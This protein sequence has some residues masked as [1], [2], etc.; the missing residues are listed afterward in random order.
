MANVNS[1]DVV[2]PSFRLDEEILLNICN[3]EIPEGVLATFYIVADNPAMEIPEGLLKLAL[4]DKIVVVKNEINL[5]FSR[6][7]NKGI[8]LGNSKWLLLLDD[9]VTPEKNLLTA[10][11]A[12]IAKH[13]DALGF[14]G[15]TN[16]PEPFDTATLALHVNGNTGHS[17]GANHHTTLMW[18]PT[19]NIMLNR[20]KMDASLFDEQLKKGGEDI[21]FLVRNALLN[22]EKYLAVNDAVVEHPWWDGGA[23]K[24]LFRYGAG[25][26][27]IAP[28]PAIKSYTYHDFTNTGE[29]LLLL[30]L[31]SP[32]IL[33]YHS[34]SFFSVLVLI[35]LVAEFITNYMRSVFL[36][37]KYSIA[38][39]SHIFWLKNCYEAGYLYESLSTGRLSGFA[40]RIELGF[41]KKHP[42]WFRLNKWKI[43]KMCLIAIGVLVLMV[44]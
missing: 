7:R 26:A 42:S 29:S 3:L 36:S 10:Y 16:F 25:A 32:L 2:V 41:V 14:A 20:E 43:V 35:L 28:L 15:I 5:G 22:D 23:T 38:L 33:L 24:R 39:A 17:K 13:P 9:D 27:Q 44:S 37:G 6:T 11:A 31:A 1:I 21:E 18:V 8:R 30:I 40:E 4:E 34:W 12:A 19:T